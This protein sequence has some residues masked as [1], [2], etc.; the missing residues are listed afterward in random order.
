M[1][2]LATCIADCWDSTR[3]IYYRAGE[4]CEIDTGSP[5]ANL[6]TT[7]NSAKRPTGRRQYVFQFDRTGTRQKPEGRR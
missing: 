5:L 4:V 2:V 7:P 1:L 3:G 6:T